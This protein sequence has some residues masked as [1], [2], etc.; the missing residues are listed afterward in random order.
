MFSQQMKVEEAVSSEHKLSITLREIVTCDQY[1]LL[2][3]RHLTCCLLL[4]LGNEMKLLFLGAIF[5]RT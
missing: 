3:D 2:C 5:L 4:L 1:L